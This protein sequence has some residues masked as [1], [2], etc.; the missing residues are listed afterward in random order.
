MEHS[1]PH[2]AFKVWM[3]TDDGYVF[4]PGVYSLLKRIMEVG[5]L[6]EAA[7][8]LGMSYRYAWG[9]IKK[10]EEKLGEPLLT[11]HKGGRSGGGGAE[12]TE[13]GKQFLV[14]FQKLREQIIRVTQTIP[15]QI[16]NGVVKE[17]K[18]YP[19]QTEVIIRIDAVDKTRLKKGENVSIYKM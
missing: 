10:A 12:L 16:I 8:E 6:K 5:T 14:E 13:R 19:D 4:G 9:L 18:L 7:T 1:K 17:I 2:P 3:E 11:A 15:Q